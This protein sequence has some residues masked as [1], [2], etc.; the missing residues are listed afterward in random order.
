[1]KKSKKFLK[2]LICV[3][4]TFTTVFSIRMI[5]ETGC[6]LGVMLN[7]GE[8]KFI[9][10]FNENKEDIIKQYDDYYKTVLETSKDEKTKELYNKYPVGTVG[11]TVQI[12][13]LMVNGSIFINSSL[14]GLILGTAIFL[15]LD[16]SKKEIKIL[17]VLYMITIVILGFIEGF[18]TIYGENLSIIDY[19]TFPENLIIPV[20]IIF[21]IIEIIYI[22]RQKNIARKLNEKL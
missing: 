14:I 9:E 12:S 3:L 5:I 13:K 15:I 4:L 18:N 1:M 19:W 20:T 10:D 21:A 11:A 17:L 6:I 16:K 2:W 7:L 22:M 8:D